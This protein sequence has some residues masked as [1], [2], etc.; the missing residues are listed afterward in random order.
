M[1]GPSS[2]HGGYGEFV[3]DVM[4]LIRSCN[5][6]LKNKWYCR[7]PM[8]LNYLSY[9]S[10]FARILHVHREVLTSIVWRQG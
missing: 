6:C 8:V 10:L 3:I 4:L 7:N 5:F 9:F 2:G 1:T